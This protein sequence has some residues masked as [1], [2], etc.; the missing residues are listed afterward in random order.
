M[1]MSL[2]LGLLQ[3]LRTLPGVALAVAQALY[4]GPVGAQALTESGVKAR[5]VLSLARFVQWPTSV[6]AEPGVLRLCVAARQAEAAAAFTGFD[7]QSIAG[8]TVRVLPLSASVPG[9]ASASTPSTSTGPPCHVLYLHSSADRAAEL[10]AQ[11]G[12]APTLTIGD[13]EG[14]LAHGG[15]VE[16][17]HTND[18]IRFDVNL[19][20][21]RTAQLELSSQVL[22]LARQVRE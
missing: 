14:F 1:R 6:G 9:S 12:R 13:T 15:M 11:A 2:R 16:L 21:L 22:K 4:G 17:L 18:A 7:G 8:R 3:R 20:A 10:L 5:L 19:K